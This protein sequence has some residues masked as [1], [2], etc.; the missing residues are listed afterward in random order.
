MSKLANSHVAITIII[1]AIFLSAC[2]GSEQAS[3]DQ[4]KP[5]EAP[6]QV[7]SELPMMTELALG[8]LKLEAS[9]Y[10]LT[11]AQAQTLLPLWKAV[12]SLSESE[13]TAEQEITAVLD[14]IQIALTAQQ[15]Q[16]ITAMEL[17]S[18]D[19]GAIA[20]ELG[21]DFG[22]GQFADL[23]PELQATMQAAR[24]GG[25]GPPA[26]LAGFQPSGIGIEPGMDGGLNP[27]Q[28]ADVNTARAGI[29]GNTNGM[30]SALL[31]GLIEYL[32]VTSS[33]SDQI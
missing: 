27:E 1:L 13:T 6:A 21:L 9:E 24:E 28:Q 14:Q 8:I 30:N 18:Q 11:P 4:A 12:R 25:Q 19:I 10:P 15:Q 2:A 20:E 23:D 31:D 33:T 5:A 3:A 16:A 7:P 29:S 26:D 17:S 32:Q 22:M